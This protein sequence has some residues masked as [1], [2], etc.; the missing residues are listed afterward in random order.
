MVPESIDMKKTV[1]FCCKQLKKKILMKPRTEGFF[2]SCLH[3]IIEGQPQDEKFLLS[4]VF[5]FPFIYIPPFLSFLSSVR[6][7]LPY[8]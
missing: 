5:F 1:P 3:V 2:Q 6:L 4:P 8:S 7:A